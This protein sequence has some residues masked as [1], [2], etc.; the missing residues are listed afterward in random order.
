MKLPIWTSAAG[1]VLVV[2]IHTPGPVPAPPAATLAPAPLVPT[3]ARFCGMPST[4]S[5]SWVTVTVAP[6]AVPGGGGVIASPATSRP[7]LPSPC[8]PLEQLTPVRLLPRQV[9]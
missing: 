8:A 6:D 4:H 5:V 3:P 9:E 2:P 7:V 1:T